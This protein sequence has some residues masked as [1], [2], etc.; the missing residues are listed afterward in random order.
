MTIQHR[1]DGVG[2]NGGWVVIGTPIDVL[3]HDWVKACRIELGFVRYEGREV[4]EALTLVMGRGF[5]SASA[6]T[7]IAQ[8]LW[9]SALFCGRVEDDN[10]LV[11]LDTPTVEEFRLEELT[12]K[13]LDSGPDITELLR[14]FVLDGIVSPARDFFTVLGRS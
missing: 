5:S 12:F 1:R 9:T 3:D 13:T 6:T 2:L 14:P 11:E 7:L 8:R 4:G 10:L